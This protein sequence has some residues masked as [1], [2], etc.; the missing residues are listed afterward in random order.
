MLQLFIF[1]FVFVGI[2]VLIFGAIQGLRAMTLVN[3]CQDQLTGFKA[4][5]RRVQERMD[6]VERSLAGAHVEPVVEAPPEEEPEPVVAPELAPTPPERLVVEVEPEPPATAPAPE[7]RSVLLDMIREQRGEQERE[8]APPETP[9]REWGDLEEIIGKRWMT[10][11]GVVVLFLSVA[12]FLKY[13]YDQG[14]LGRITPGMRVTIGAM[15]GA[16]LLVAGDRFVRKH[17][18]ALGQG[19]IGGGLAILYLSLFAAYQMY[20]IMPQTVAFG[21]MVIVSA[22]GIALAVLHDALPVSF[23]AVLGGFMT[24]VML[25]QDARD[26]LFSY[27]TLL[28][29]SVL[30]VALF[31][32]WRPLDM[33]A[34]VGTWVLFAAWFGNHYTSLALVPTAAWLLAFFF[35]FLILPFVYHL[36]H[37]TTTTVYQFMMSLSHATIS[38]CFLYRVLHADHHRLLAWFV[39]GM[40]GCYTALGAISRK[41]VPDDA[42]GLFGFITLA[43]VLLTAAVPIRLN[44]YGVTIAW[45]I[46]GPAL[47]YLGYRFRYRPVRFG[48]L[49]VLLLSVLRIFAVHWPLHR[50]AFTPILNGAFLSV[51]WVPA[52]LVVYA[53]IHRLH[54][55]EA[56]PEDRTLRAAS[57][58]AAGFLTLLILQVEVGQ[59]LKLKD[60]PNFARCAVTLVW[61][62]GSAAFLAAGL[63]LRDVAY[64]VSGLVA[65]IIA[66][67][68]VANLHIQDPRGDYFLLLSPRFMTMML[69]GAVIFVTASLFRR[70]RD[71]CGK[72]ETEVGRYLFVAAGIFLLLGLSVE[73]HSYCIQTIADLVQAKSMARM[74]V[75]IVWLFG[76]IAFLSVGFRTSSQLARAVG[77]VTL[78]LTL[79]LGLHLHA[80]DARGSAALFLSPRFLTELVVVATMF[81]YARFLH[82]YREIVTEQERTIGQK[83]W[84]A[85]TLLLLIVMTLEV[86]SFWLQKLAGEPNAKWVAR[87][88]VTIL[89]GLY[90]SASLWIGFWRRVRALRLAALG[91]FGLTALKLIFVDLAGVERIYQVLAF[92]VTGGLMIGA[93]YL[94]HRLEQ[95]LG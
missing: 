49:V 27:V 82:R 6:A 53:V 83:L 43:V 60:L 76:S 87:M 33:L 9:A 44:L 32:R 64:R 42:R 85:A 95:R 11:A 38:F 26:A 3:E 13:A 94:Y 65:L 20:G 68:G 35:T 63:K 74:L 31:K 36:R 67:A 88:S 14:W 86:D 62:L 69:V 52:A 40:S 50:A 55:R 17:M 12:L 37:C 80:L 28:N 57:A 81:G 93:S 48:G 47:V 78:A 61:A 45:A 59:G 90:A 29:L 24:P 15:F 72:E 7:A 75:T 10:W 92:L 39:L 25:E 30:G 91:L 5:L 22:G 1:L 2:P 4:A 77:T 56:S 21:L 70:N 16:G 23:L 73:F 54:D 34:F 51:I 46:E 58:I 66:I 18:R 84:G 19:L 8:A 41:R 89:W 79:C 71:L